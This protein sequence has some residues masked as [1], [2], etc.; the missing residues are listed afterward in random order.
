[1]SKRLFGGAIAPE[2][3]RVRAKGAIE[4]FPFLPLF[5]AAHTRKLARLLACFPLCLS[6]SLSLSAS[7]LARATQQAN[8][9]NLDGRSLLDKLE[10]NGLGGTGAP[11]RADSIWEPTSGVPLDGGRASGR[12]RARLVARQMAGGAKGLI[13]W[14]AL[15]A[16]RVHYL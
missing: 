8:K 9:L 5:A 16:S 7:L 3:Q 15:L 4:T 1:V 2:S 12:G 13:V 14:H 10:F 6:V 11:R